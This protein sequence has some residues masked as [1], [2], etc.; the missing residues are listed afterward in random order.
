[1][2]AM[3]H[4]LRVAVRVQAFL[5]LAARIKEDL[6]D[7]GQALRV[8]SRGQRIKPDQPTFDQREEVSRGFGRE[9]RPAAGGAVDRRRVRSHQVGPAGAPTR[10]LRRGS[11]GGC[12]WLPCQTVSKRGRHQFRRIKIVLRVS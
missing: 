2:P 3:M 7:P 8:R 4:L 12:G 1:M 6:A 5:E 9:L 10:L 11:M